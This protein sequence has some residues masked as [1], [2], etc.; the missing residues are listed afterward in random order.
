M[1]GNTVRDGVEWIVS[2]RALLPIPAARSMATAESILIGLRGGGWEKPASL[3]ALLAF[4]RNLP[5]DFPYD[6][7]EMS[8][9]SFVFTRRG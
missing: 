1:S 7:E 4:L 3:D 8:P 9:G 6:A 5:A 2:Q